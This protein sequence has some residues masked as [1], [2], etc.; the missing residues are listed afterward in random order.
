MSQERPIGKVLYRVP[1][2]D[3]DQM[4]FVYYGNYLTYFERSRNELMRTAGF[5]YTRLE[6]LGIG[7]PVVEA[8][9][10]Y[11][12]PARYDDLLVIE[13]VCT[14]SK[15]VRM[16]VENRVLR[17]EELLVEGFTVHAF[18]ELRTGRPTKPNQELLKT[19]GL[20]GE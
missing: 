4:G 6:A 5:P 20:D 8:G 2:A 11:R 15:G 3:T 13:A 18:M 7:L 10:R 16:R 12:R 14:A 17:G 1:Y 9:V 19:F